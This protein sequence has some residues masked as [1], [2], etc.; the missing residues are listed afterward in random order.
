MELVI[1]GIYQLPPHQID[2][3]LFFLFS[4]LD[5]LVECTGLFRLPFGCNTVSCWPEWNVW[6]LMFQEESFAGEKLDGTVALAL[7]IAA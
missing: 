6:K 2:I 4:R 7:A 1:S 5:S 3:L